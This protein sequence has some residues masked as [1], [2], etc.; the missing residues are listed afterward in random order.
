[1]KRAH[2]L[3][4]ALLLAACSREPAA[5]PKKQADPAAPPSDVVAAKIVFANRGVPGQMRVFEPASQ[6]P[7]ELWETKTVGTLAEA[8]IGAEL[9]GGAMKLAPGTAK[10][11]VLVLENAG[12]DAIHFFASPHVVDPPE[13]SLGFKFKCL[14]INHA[15]SV[16]AGKTWYRVV[17]LTL[18]EDFVGSE[19]EIS[20]DLISVPGSRAGQ[21]KMPGH[22]H[23][24][25][26]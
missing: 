14:C 23:E 21:V 12:K 5:V 13:Y 3:G 11:F 24:S 15:F 22:Q 18:A 7:V 17:R 8:P 20:H 10:T 25:T 4:L 2:A 16:E 6:R 26:D 1:M 9:A 19:L